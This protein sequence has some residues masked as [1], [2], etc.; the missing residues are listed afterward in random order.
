MSPARQWP[1]AGKTPWVML[2]HSAPWAARTPGRVV[3]G[4]HTLPEQK[5][6]C[7]PTGETDLARFP[8][9]LLRW[10]CPEA[11]T[12]PHL[13]ESQPHVLV[14][15]AAGLGS[16]PKHELLLFSVWSEAVDILR[17]SVSTEQL[18]PCCLYPKFTPKW[19]LSGR[20]RWIMQ[21]GTARES[22]LLEDF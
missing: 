6:P 18:P 5:H 9:T 4:R 2:G 1:Q 13:G 3:S 12:S 20:F 7:H 14:Q 11:H 15:V 17:T 16:E 8:N 19:L 21:R 10:G 22:E